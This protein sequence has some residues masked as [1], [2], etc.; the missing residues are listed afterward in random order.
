MLVMDVS[1]NILDAVPWM[2]DWTEVMFAWIHQKKESDS[3]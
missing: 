2:L 1:F 3:S